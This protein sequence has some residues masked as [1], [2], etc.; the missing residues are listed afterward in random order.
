MSGEEDPFASGGELDDGGDSGFNPFD[1]SELHYSFSLTPKGLLF[2][3][4]RENH[5]LRGVV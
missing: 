5:L 3:Q 4:D 1:N 2:R